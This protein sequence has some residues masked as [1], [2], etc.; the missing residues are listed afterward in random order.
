[1]KAA[2]LDT[3]WD[4]NRRKMDQGKLQQH[5]ENIQETNLGN[6]ASKKK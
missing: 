4:K 6:Q 2:E 5:S 3:E 1:M